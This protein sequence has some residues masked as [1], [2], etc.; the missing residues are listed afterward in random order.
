VCAPQRRLDGAF[1]FLWVVACKISPSTHTEGKGG[2][3]R[4]REILAVFD[5]HVVLRVVGL[6]AERV[7]PR[8]EVIAKQGHD[9]GGLAVV[10]LLQ[11][12][13][14]RERLVEGVLRHLVT[15]HLLLL[16]LVVE[17]REVKHETKRDG[18]RRLEGARVL[19]R[20]GVGRA[21]CR[22]LSLCDSRLRVED[23]DVVAVVVGLQ[24][25]VEYAGL[26]VGRVGNKALREVGEDVVA[27]LA[28]LGLHAGLELHHG[29]RLGL[30]LEG[31]Q[32]AP[33]RAAGADD[34]FVRHGEEILL[35]ECERGAKLDEPLQAHQHLVV[36]LTLLGDLRHDD[37]TT[38][39]VGNLEGHVRAP[40][41]KKLTANRATRWTTHVSDETTTPGGKDFT[42][43]CVR[44]RPGQYA[45]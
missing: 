22:T 10:L 16:D 19:H 13:Q 28:D 5:L 31:L 23:L 42:K 4:G 11:A 14:V 34:V 38:A 25:V 27:D 32:G 9:R 6:H 3:R 41:Y 18:A 7:G 1:S 29:I 17:H 8:V 35:L 30:L 20:L 44:N 43:R 37:Q 12:V 21:R 45:I 2:W 26:V 40:I 36:A 24:L 33:R 15:R 39:V